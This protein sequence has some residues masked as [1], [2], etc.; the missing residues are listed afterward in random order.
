MS[1][2][3]PRRG[4][5]SIPPRQRRVVAWTAALLAVAGFLYIVTL[6]MRQSGFTVGDHELVKGDGGAAI[7]GVLHNRG[8]T[9]PL[10][11]VEAYLYDAAGVYLATSGQSY[12][13]V[14]AGSSTP[15]RLPNEP[16][17]A[18]RVERYTVYAGVT[19]NPFAPGMD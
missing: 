12:R 2:A 13:D 10:V 9:A 18:A 3:T 17:F 1:E 6:P 5:R 15:V 14:T 11:R 7:E 8:E 4:S 16:A 19:P